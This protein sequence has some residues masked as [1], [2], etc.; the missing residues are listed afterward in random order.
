MRILNKYI[1][2][3]LLFFSYSGF[4]QKA[5][6]LKKIKDQK[7]TEIKLT[8]SLINETNKKKSESLNQLS[9]IERKIDVRNK[10]LKR[11]NVELDQIN[12]TIDENSKMIGVLRN[13]KR[14]ILEEYGKIIYLSYKFKQRENFLI[15]I[16]AA[17]NFNQAYKRIKYVQ[18]YLVYKQKQKKL[19]DAY[20]R[21]LNLKNE[22][23]EIQKNQSRKVFKERE[24]ERNL[25]AKE[26][27]RKNDIIKNLQGKEKELKKELSDKK[28]EKERIANEIEKIIENERKKGRSKNIYE[29]LTPTEKVLSSEFEKNKG[30]LPWPTNHG[31]ITGRFGFQQHPVLKDVKVRNDGIYISTI[32]NEDAM[33]IFDG[34]VSKI[35]SVQGSNYTVLIKHGNFFTLY[36]NLSQIYV[37]EGDVVKIKQKIGKIFTDGDKNETILHF[38]VLKETERSDPE[39]WLAR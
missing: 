31:I 39:M 38:Q 30:K 4:S 26:K 21:V 34:I 35:F 29:S 28:K 10:Y 27:N 17:E 19:I 36:N 1:L 18:M 22:E 2:I 3:I 33:A 9:I 8:E 24:E 23:L 37:K 5:N 32:K 16:L 7:E 14:K 13:D 11:L 25:L 15:Y 6:E 20:E 12:K